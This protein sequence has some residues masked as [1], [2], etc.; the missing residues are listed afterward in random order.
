M[1]CCGGGYPEDR[2][3]TSVDKNFFCPI[4]TDVL[5]DP[6]QCHNQHLFCRACITEHLK[7]SQTCPVCMEKLTE[8]ALSKPARIVT[9]ILDGLMVNCEHKE[10][11]CV[12]LVELG[13]LETHISVCEYKPVTCPN[14]RCE[15]VVN[16]AD[17]EEHTSEV[18]EYRQV[19]C[20][21]CDENMSLKKYEKHGCFISKDVQA[22]KVVLFQMQHQVKTVQDQVKEMSNRQNEM[23]E[24]IQNL[25]TAV[26]KLSTTSGRAES[27]CDTKPQGNIVVIGGQ[28]GVINCLNSVEVYSLANQTWSKLAPMQQ[29]RAAATAHFYNGQVMVTGGFY[30]MAIATKSIEYVRI[31]EELQ[32][33][34]R[35]EP[36]NTAYQDEF[37]SLL[38]QL[39]FEGYG[40][41]TAIINDQVWLVGGYGINNNQG[42]SSN[43]IYTKPIRSTGTFVVKRRLPKPLSFHGLEIING[44]ELLIIGG[45]TAGFTHYAVNTVWS[46]N[47]VTNTLREL[48]P[49]PFPM[50]DMATVKHGEDVIII[51]GQNKERGY[52]NTVFKYNH[53]KRVCKQLPGM[54]YKRGECAAVISGNRVFVMGGY[55]EEQ[56]YLS[57]VE[58]FDLQHQVWHELPPMSE[59]KFK[60][61]AVL[62]P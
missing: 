41:K 12:E 45:S 40:H 27:T 6:V 59:A 53:K 34:V 2:F 24:A 50:V 44:N 48:H 22:M 32:S 43:A 13:L 57:S 15:A 1:A 3:Q 7:N 39:P 51:G 52:L 29:K 36:T 60:I 62:V 30:D 17:L 8:E 20:E 14:E 47:T 10:R 5:K 35:P 38:Y 49:L 31:C 16:M 61:A 46:Y 18:C 56:G 54:K 26:S 4:C 25:T 11:G 28:N 23:F 33:T 55:N 9:N 37:S 21:E 42:Q 58:C 19:F